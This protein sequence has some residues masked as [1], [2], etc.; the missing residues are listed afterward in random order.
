[1]NQ[2][3]ASIVSP[4]NR[5]QESSGAQLRKV[6]GQRP[7]RTTGGA[8]APRSHF[9]YILDQV[10]TDGRTEGGGRDGETIPAQKHFLK[11]I[12]GPFSSYSS[13][14][15]HDEAREVRLASAAPPLH[16]E[17]T[18]SCGLPTRTAFPDSEG[19]RAPT[20]A[21]SRSGSPGSSV[22]PPSGRHGPRLKA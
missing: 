19:T 20:S 16:T 7:R 13:W 3:P 6:T 8:A 17:K 12:W 1:M 2:R 5:K 21:W 22:L 9:I 14:L 18:R 15:I 11:T 10:Q 4:L